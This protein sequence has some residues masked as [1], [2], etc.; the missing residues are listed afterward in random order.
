MLIALRAA[1]AAAQALEELQLAT[2]PD[3]FWARDGR[4]HA[5]VLCLHFDF[6]DALD[7]TAMCPSL[8]RGFIHVLGFSRDPEAVTVS[9]RLGLPPGVRVSLHDG[10]LASQT[11]RRN[12]CYAR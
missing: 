10:S 3:D 8:R 6:R 7:L 5:C 12:T 11:T 9:T 2:D 4:R 1:P